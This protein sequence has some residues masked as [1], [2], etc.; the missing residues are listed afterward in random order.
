[1]SA[2]ETLTTPRAISRFA[3]P[4]D[5]P[6]AHVVDPVQADDGSITF[7]PSTT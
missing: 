7:E 4:A 3:R 2:V 6:L 5:L 1:M